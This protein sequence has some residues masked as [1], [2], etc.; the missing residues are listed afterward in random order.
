MN[1]E[2]SHALDSVRSVIRLRQ[3]FKVLGD[4]ESPVDLSDTQVDEEFV[5]QGIADAGWAPFHY[6][7]NPNGV[8]EPWRCHVLWHPACR[9]LAKLMPQW[10]S[11]MKPTNKLPA[12][13]SACGAMVMVT[14]VP[15]TLEE[16]SDPEK[17][18]SINEE[19]LAA[20]SAMV[21]NLLLV[22][23]AAGYGTYW[24]SGGQFKSPTMFEK[25]SVP[26]QEKLSA[27]V[28]IEYPQTQDREL[29]RLAG[30]N[31]SKR[32]SS[33]KWMREVQIP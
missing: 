31:R 6:A 9:K 1:E 23:T 21:Q 17:L 16:V 32:A 3:T 24:S 28:F 12:M 19:H 10:F 4:V 27:A 14:W 20:T 25:L 11:D 26:A 15:Q 2:N 29:E 8:A 22:C 33:D 18:Q 5:R 7:R 30:K 13:L